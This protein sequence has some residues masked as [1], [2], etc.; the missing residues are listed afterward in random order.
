ML[1]L[2]LHILNVVNSLMHGVHIYVRSYVWNEIFSLRHTS[3]MQVDKFN[4]EMV[5]IVVSGESWV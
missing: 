4:G 3:C 5:K 2:S 1:S